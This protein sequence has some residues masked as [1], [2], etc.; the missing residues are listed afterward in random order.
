MTTTTCVASTDDPGHRPWLWH[1]TRGMVHG[2]H[3]GVP[4]SALGMTSPWAEGLPWV[5]TCDNC[6]SFM[7]IKLEQEEV[8]AQ[9]ASPAA[10]WGTFVSSH[11]STCCYS[12]PLRSPPMVSSHRKRFSIS[13]FFFN[14]CFLTSTNNPSLFIFT[15]FYTVIGINIVSSIWLIIDNTSSY[16]QCCLNKYIPIKS[17]YLKT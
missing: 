13:L 10:P 15:R 12:W 9:S 6:P 2:W 16:F 3:E 14:Y 11:C 17:Y 4:G 1:T 7:Y 8:L 5:A